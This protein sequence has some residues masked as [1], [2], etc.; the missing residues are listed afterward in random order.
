MADANDGIISKLAGLSLR[1][2]ELE[3]RIADPAVASSKEYPTLVREH[4]RLSRVVGPIKSSNMRLSAYVKPTKCW[5]TQRWKISP[6][7]IGRS[8]GDFDRLLE[9]V[10]ASSFK[11]MPWQIA[12]PLSKYAP[13]QAAMKPRSLPAIWCACIKCTRSAAAGKSMSS[14]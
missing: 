14:N 10:K 1:F 7:R 12:P 3:Q 2:A 13:E 6:G 11:V 8:P 5:A 4:G 9:E